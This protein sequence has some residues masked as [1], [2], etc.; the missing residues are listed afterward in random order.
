MTTKKVSP[1]KE[2]KDNS[3]EKPEWVNIYST[4]YGYWRYWVKYILGEGGITKFR[5]VK[6]KGSYNGKIAVSKAEIDK[7]EKVLADYKAKHPDEKEMWR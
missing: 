2:S 3:N 5:F 7:T 1:K 4:T 6:D